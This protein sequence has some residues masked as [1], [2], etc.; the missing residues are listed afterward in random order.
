MLAVN[1]AEAAIARGV[2]RGSRLFDLETARAA[3][4]RGTGRPADREQR[5]RRG[6]QHQRLHRRT[7]AG[8]GAAGH[9]DDGIPHVMRLIA[10]NQFDTIHHE[11]VSYFSL[12]AVGY[13]LE[14]NGLTIYDVDELDTHAARWDLCVSP[15]DPLRPVTPRVDR[16]WRASA[17]PASAHWT[18]TPSLPIG[19]AKRSAS[20]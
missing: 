6:A 7:E 17:T 19:C 5:D 2:P 20:C 3:R 13:V 4:G 8:D 14:S 9:F 18:I 11:R 12:L 10:D 16:S 15:R 1:V